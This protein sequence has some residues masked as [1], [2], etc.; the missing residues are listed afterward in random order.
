MPD[1]SG[2]IQSLE[3][4]SWLWLILLFPIVGALGNALHASGVLGAAWHAIRFGLA[5]P[6][7]PVPAPARTAARIAT[8]SLG[9]SLATSVVACATLAEAP[10]S[11]RALFC[12]VWPIVRVGQLDVGFDL[13]MDP[14][15]AALTLAVVT[16]A[17]LVTVHPRARREAGGDEHAWR[18]FACLGSFV[19]SLLVALLADNL[20]LVLAGL[21]GAGLTGLVL[22]RVSATPGAPAAATRLDRGSLVQALGDAA[23]LAAVALLFWGLGG[24]WTTTGEYQPD[25]DPRVVAVNTTAGNTPLRADDPALRG[26]AATQ[27]RGFITVL[28]LP[29]ALVYSDDSRT[30]LL[31]AA[32]LPLTTPFVRHEV[33]GGAHVFRVAPDDGFTRTGHG[34]KAPFALEGGALPNY[35]VPRIAMGGD[36]EVALSVVGPTLRFRE[37]AD[38]L[39][40]EDAKRAMPRRDALVAR[41]LVGGSGKRGGLGLVTVVCA[42]FLVGACAKGSELPRVVWRLRASGEPFTVAALLPGSGMLLAGVYLVARLG[43]LFSLL[44]AS[45]P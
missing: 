42:L 20:V 12:H 17:V 43:F 35:T 36:R 16:L 3:L 2:P 30:P 26:G 33:P 5:E 4:A 14:L 25:L 40:F 13:A 38:Q 1:Y 18:F 6:R 22:A 34:A 19:A 11:E 29:G 44:G 24:A 10:S 21:Q 41:R 39:A 45:P 32:G 27:G 37:L 28:G 9:L 15:A 23:T 8:V 7:P 31:D